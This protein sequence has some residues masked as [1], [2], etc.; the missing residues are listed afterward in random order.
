MWGGTGGRGSCADSRKGVVLVMIA[1]RKMG[2]QGTVN[3]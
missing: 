1:T 2:C 3:G